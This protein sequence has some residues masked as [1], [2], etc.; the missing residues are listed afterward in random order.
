MKRLWEWI[1]AGYLRLIEP[2]ADFLVA[3]RVNPN[4]ITTVGTLCS[5]AG[6]VIY[7]TGH[8]SL[9]GWVIGLTAL[10]DVLDGT[11]ARRTGRSTV[12]GAF[13]DSTLDRVADG[14]VL[15]GL[16]VF[17]AT[18]AEHYSVPML[19]V[20]LLGIIGTFLTS[21]TRARAEALGIDAKVGIMQRPERVTLLSAP[22]A[23]FGLALNGWIL[24]GIVV[25][26]S[27][28]A[29]ITAV[30]RIAFV[31]RVTK[32]AGG[33]GGTRPEGRDEPLD[34]APGEP[35]AGSVTTSRADVARHAYTR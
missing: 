6:G 33:G 5:A 22:Q 30:Q 29:W 9:A 34:G 12:F 14:I 16:T 31:Y 23:F 1:Q 32:V 17:Y 20:S 15:G 24:A 11:V 3:R 4:T 7:A 19:V 21:Y 28:T 8:I 2:V 10:F 27:V 13:Y 18:S 26:L 35:G 25:L